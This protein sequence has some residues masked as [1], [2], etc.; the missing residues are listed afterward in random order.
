M[1]FLESS[2]NESSVDFWEAFMAL[3]LLF[4]EKFTEWEAFIFK[5][6]DNDRDGKL[7]KTEIHEMF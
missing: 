1:K 3:L 4:E 5:L 6:F 2:E 7:S